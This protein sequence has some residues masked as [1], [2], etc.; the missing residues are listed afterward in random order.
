MSLSGLAK[1]VLGVFLAIA[2]LLTATGATAF[3]FLTKLTTAPAKPLFAEEQPKSKPAAKG[4]TA[5]VASKS[6]PPSSKAS[7]SATPEEPSTPKPLEPGAYKGRV[8]WPQG[9]SM[10]DEPNLDAKKIGGIG[11]NETIVVLQESADKK[12]QQVR[13]ET[14]EEKGWVKAGNIE[15]VDENAEKAKT[16]SAQ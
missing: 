8:S 10:R 13:G 11:F 6:T 7:A 15:R 2:L 1:F 16:E 14:G 9:L 4:K 12:W 3:Y 5:S